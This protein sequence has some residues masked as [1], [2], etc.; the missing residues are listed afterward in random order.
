[1][2]RTMKCTIECTMEC[3]IERIMERIKEDI[4]Q[5]NAH[6]RIPTIEI[7]MI[8]L[9]YNRAHNRAYDRA[10]DRAYNKTYDNS[11]Q[12]FTRTPTPTRPCLAEPS[13][14]RTDVNQTLLGTNAN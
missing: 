11:V 9:A 12:E 10:Y 1:M 5:E 6:D 14:Q 8:K 4:I 13:H 3:T 7:C 2:E